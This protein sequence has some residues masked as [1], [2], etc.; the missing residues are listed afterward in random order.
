MAAPYS[1][2]GNRPRTH[3]K[4]PARKNPPPPP[5]PT[6]SQDER[7]DAGPL[8]RLSRAIS[9]VETVSLALRAWEPDPEMG[10]ICVC[11][12]LACSQLHR[13]HGAVDLALMRVR[14]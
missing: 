3:P 8:D 10:P 13:A 5:A 12:T 4:R 1:T 6:T 9:L 11:L 2:G 7:E 14:P